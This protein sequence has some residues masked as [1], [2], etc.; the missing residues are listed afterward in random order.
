MEQELSLEWIPKNLE[1]IRRRIVQASERAGRPPEEVTL[2]AV[3]KTVGA[4]LINAAVAAGADTLGENRVQEVLA[5]RDAVPPEV[6]WHLIGHL[7][8][9]KVRQIIDKVA[10]IHSLDSRHLAEELQKRAEQMDLTVK[11]LVEVNVGAE[12]SKFGLSPDQVAPF[13]KSLSDLDRVHILGLMTV[14]P[15]LEDLESVRMVFRSLKRLFDEMKELNLPN[16]QMLHLSMGMT[17]DF[18]VAIEE[19]ATMVRVGTGIFGA[20]DYTV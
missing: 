4:D 19:G 12:D 6:S 9:N 7:Q 15:F 17:H 2:I 1:H 8:T 5:K 11:V 16:V 10:L 18:E 3:S 13:L 14:A 20:R